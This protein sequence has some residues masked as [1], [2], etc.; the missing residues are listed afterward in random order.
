MSSETNCN[1]GCGDGTSATSTPNT[2]V[3]SWPYFEIPK[4]IV[5]IGTGDACSQTTKKIL[6]GSV[7]EELD[8]FS[9]NN[10]TT[11]VTTTGLSFGAVRIE[12]L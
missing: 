6:V 9:K 1:C 2:A 5:Y 8:E 10:N 12:R 11:F 3:A 7:K 4:Y